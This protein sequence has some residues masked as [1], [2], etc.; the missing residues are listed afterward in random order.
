MRNKLIAGQYYEGKLLMQI[1]NLAY[2]TQCP[3]KIGL[4]YDRTSSCLDSASISY[5]VSCY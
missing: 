3:T 4:N 1:D 2:Y 5:S